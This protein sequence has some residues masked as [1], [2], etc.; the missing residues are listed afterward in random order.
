MIQAFAAAAILSLA[1]QAAPADRTRAVELARAGRTTE[2]LALF[3]QIAAAHP[4]DVDAR[5]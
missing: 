1:M 2:A 5:L 3:E 4:D